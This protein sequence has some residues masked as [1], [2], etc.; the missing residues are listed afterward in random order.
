MSCSL[1][2]LL[3]LGSLGSLGE[4][5]LG[6]HILPC[7]ISHFCLLTRVTSSVTSGSVFTL[8]MCFCTKQKCA[9][10]AGAKTP[11]PSHTASRAGVC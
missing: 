4:E 2:L 11:L 8:C 1:V 5:K 9:S 10:T 7:H 6:G 3:K